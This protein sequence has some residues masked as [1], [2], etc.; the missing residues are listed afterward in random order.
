MINKQQTIYTYSKAHK[1]KDQLC[2]PNLMPEHRLAESTGDRQEHP[3]PGSAC[4][5]PQTGA[6][7]TGKAPRLPTS[8]VMPDLTLLLTYLLPLP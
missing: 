5:N 2:V 6:L 8:K 7:E 3:R 4:W 1:S